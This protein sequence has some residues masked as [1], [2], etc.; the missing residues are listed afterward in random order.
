M[1]GYSLKIT[2]IFLMLCL[3]AKADDPGPAVWMEPYSYLALGDSYT[4]GEGVPSYQRWPVQLVR[5]LRN[6]VPVHRPK[7]IA[8]TGWTTDELLGAISGINMNRKYDLVS[9]LIGVNN[10]YRGYPLHYFREEFPKLLDIA[11]HLA[12]GKRKRVFVVSIPNYAATPFGRRGDPR[13]ITRELKYYN[14]IAREICRKKGVRFINITDI[15]ERTGPSLVAHDDLHPSGKM[16][17][18]WVR[19]IYPEVKRMLAR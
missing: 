12:R 14:R 5:A 2:V 1:L 4:I 18:L 19:R 9:L 13:K 8:T 7:I 16:Y 3:P 11:I 15:S 10:Q 6:H 17:S